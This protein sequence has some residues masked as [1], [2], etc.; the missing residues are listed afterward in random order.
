MSEICPK[1]KNTTESNPCEWC[2]HQ[3]VDD[4]LLQ[5][6]SQKNILRNYETTLNFKRKWRYQGAMNKTTII[7]DDV[8]SG[9]LKNGKKLTLS[10]RTKDNIVIRADCLGA[11]SGLLVLKKPIKEEYFIE[12]KFKTGFLKGQVI[13]E[14]MNKDMFNK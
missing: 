10:H 7:I 8:N 9:I 2:G 12:I 1:C 13:L 4:L 14:L 6:E 3:L 11:K 5:P